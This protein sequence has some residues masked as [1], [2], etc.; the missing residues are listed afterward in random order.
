MEESRRTPSKTDAQPTAVEM[1]RLRSIV[2]RA[3]E[4]LSKEEADTL[5]A[6]I[7][8]LGVVT[9]ELESKKASIK[10]L[11]RLIFGQQDEGL[12]KLL[13]PEVAKKTRQRGK[14][15]S[16]AERQKKKRKGKGRN[17]A[18]SYTGAT[19]KQVKH[20]TCEPKGSCPVCP[21]GRVYLQKQPKKL[22]R[23]KGMAPLTATVYEMERLRCNLCGEVFTAET[24]EGV[25]ERKYDESAVAMLG[26]LKYGSGVPFYRLAGLQR[27]L[28]IPMPAATQWKLLLEAESDSIG[29]AYQELIRQAAQGEVLYNDDTVM[30]IL[31]LNG[32]EVGEILE[33][34]DKPIKKGKKRKGSY[35]SGIVSVGNGQKSA[36][37]FT[38]RK[39][40]GENLADVLRARAEELGEPIQMCDG[41][42]ASTAGDYEA[43]VA[44]C[45]AHGRRKFV[46][47]YDNFPEQC[48]H[49]LDVMGS[50]YHFDT[51]AKEQGLEPEAR[52]LFH[53]KHS[54]PLLEKLKKWTE[55]LFENKEVEPNSS[56]G[57]SMNYLLKRWD[58]LTLFLR[59]PSAPLDNNIVERALK[60]PILN[61]KNAYFFKTE[62]GARVGDAFMSLIYT[63][64]LNNANPFDY[65]IALQKHR[66]LVSDAPEQW[67]PW[68][69]IQSIEAIG[70]SG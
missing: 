1:K 57:S 65:L 44:N 14:R 9:Q 10:R 7:E 40:A 22:V 70:G 52:L 68:N 20:K 43:Q 21:T 69:F 31:Q 66:D 6:A 62:N 39:H 19:R 42:A 11:R 67:M 45:L 63:C 26:L 50:I 18:S 24:P 56:L 38:G 29:P 3:Q 49:I 5:G 59:L 32:Q 60:K 4:V 16:K 28:G 35:T 47:I 61:R 15:L 8:T 30:K 64:E 51:Q 33:G 37:F 55:D 41:L 34:A 17:G 54:K 53:Q 13:G 23:I 46:E 36:L 27:Q 58:K 25:G 2:E 12:D 48:L